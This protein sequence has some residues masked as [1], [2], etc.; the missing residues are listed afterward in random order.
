MRHV[1]IACGPV[2]VVLRDGTEL[3]VAYLDG[4]A[5]D[6]RRLGWDLLGAWPDGRLLTIA[7]EQVAAV[8]TADGTELEFGDPHFPGHPRPAVMSAGAVAA[9]DHLPEIAEPAHPAT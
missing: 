1:D 6:L 8:R 4:G 9:L 7:Q 3:P 5:V 2:T